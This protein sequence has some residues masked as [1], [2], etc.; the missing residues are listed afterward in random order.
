MADAQVDAIMKALNDWISGLVTRVNLDIVAI[1]KK[2]TPI[3]T[4]WAR[5]NWIPSIG[6][7]VT[8]TVG[9]RADAENGKLDLGPQ[10]A[11]EALLTRYRIAQGNV[12]VSNNVH[13]IEKLNDGSS[14]QAPR[15]FVQRAISDAI[16]KNGG[17]A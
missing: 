8:S 3:D 16:S 1:L 5:S 17:S 2:T 14:Q 6:S 4:G 10:A 9:T 7:D 15:A 11:G 12:Y 13:Y